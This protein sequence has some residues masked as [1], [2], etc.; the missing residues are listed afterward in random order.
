MMRILR[1]G[2]MV[3]TVAALAGCRPDGKSAEGVAEGFVDAH[4]VR[5]DL[6]A[7]APFCRGV[8]LR[9]LQEE[10]RLTQGQPID[11][12]T[13]KPT[14]RYRV[15]EKRAEDG[16]HAT[17][18]FEGTIRVEDAG[19]FTRKWLVTTSRSSDVWKVSNFEEFD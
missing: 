10:Q 11:E 13:R 9:K 19:Q 8:A 1:L 15:I 14:V 6:Q 17:F 4:Y 18:I 16:D 12:S 7:A 5:I 3:L 2:M